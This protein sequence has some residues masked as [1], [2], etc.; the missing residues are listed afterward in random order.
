[1]R[2][3]FQQLDIIMIRIMVSKFQFPFI[4]HNNKQQNSLHR[5][6]IYR[7]CGAWSVIQNIDTLNISRS[8]TTDQNATTSN[9]LTFV[10]M[11]LILLYYCYSWTTI[12][13]VLLFLCI[14]RYYK[15]SECNKG[16][17]LSL[18]LIY[19]QL[20]IVVSTPFYFYY[21][22]T[23]APK[24]LQQSLLEHH[25]IVLSY[26]HHNHLLYLPLVVY[27][28]LTTKHYAYSTTSCSRSHYYYN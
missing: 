16:D 24:K 14:I 12:E 9:K 17:A 3:R 22:S 25:I 27:N 28:N 2:S 26:H 20:K 13:I 6:I 10:F 1:M 15:Q 7:L 18:T 19:E 4:R 21:Y 11:L 23:S 5:K 8:R